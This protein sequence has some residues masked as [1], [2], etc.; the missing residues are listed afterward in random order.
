M[1]FRIPVGSGGTSRVDA[2]TI[3]GAPLLPGDFNG[4]GRVDA[5]DYVKWRKSDGSPFGYNT[6]RTH[7][8]TAGGAGS[9]FA[10]SS[11]PEPATLGLV[12]FMLAWVF[13]RQRR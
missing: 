10:A 9:G 4:D 1:V 7:F 6:W 3:L 13:L 5:A 8:G 11:V 12:G 2:V